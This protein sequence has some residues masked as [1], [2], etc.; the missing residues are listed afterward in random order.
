MQAGVGGWRRGIVV[1]ALALALGLGLGG[2]ATEMKTF[3]DKGGRAPTTRSTVPVTLTRAEAARVAEE[4]R[5]CAR[6]RKESRVR[7]TFF[8]REI[9]AL[10]LQ[11]ATARTFSGSCPSCMPAWVGVGVSGTVAVALGVAL[12]VVLFQAK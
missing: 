5:L 1:V 9:A 2:C 12:L 11:I 3:R 8:E 4:L 7:L 10:R 6:D